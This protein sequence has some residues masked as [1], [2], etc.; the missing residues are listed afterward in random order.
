MVAVWIPRPGVAS[1]LAARPARRR[2]IAGMVVAG[3][4]AAIAAALGIPGRATYGAQVSADEPQYLLTALSLAEDGDLAVTDEL[5]AERYRAFHEAELPRQTAERPDG[6]HISPHD[7]LLP[8]M[9]APAMAIGGWIAAKLTLAAMAGVLA[10]LTVWTAVARFEVPLRLSVVTT[11]A[12]GMSAPLAVY[13]HQVYPELPAALIVLGAVAAITGPDR[14]PA[15]AGAVAAVI[16]LPWLGIKYAPVAATLAALLAWRL[17]TRQRARFAALTALAGVLAVAGGVYL[18]AHVAWYGGPTVYT[19][20]DFFA[21]NGG[22][23]AVVG[24]APDYLGRARRLLGLLVDRTFGVAAWQPAWLLMVPAAGAL[25]R[26]RPQRW[27]ALAWP[28]VVGWLVA[29]FVAV[30]MHGWWFPGRQVVAVLPLG[31][32]GVAWWIAQSGSRARL[33]AFAGLAALGVWS[34]G[35]LVA[36][37]ATGAVTWIVDFFRVPDPWFQRWRLFLPDYWHV[38]PGTW[39]LHVVWLIG[40]AAAFVSAWRAAARPVRRGGPGG[41]VPEAD[42]EPDP[43]PEPEPEAGGQSTLTLALPEPVVCSEPATEPLA[44]AEPSGDGQSVGPISRTPAPS[45]VPPHA[46]ST[47]AANTATASRRR[48]IGLL[49]L[50]DAPA[51]CLLVGVLMIKLG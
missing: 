39:V 28:F 3:L 25:L 40:L 22:Q 10:A 37:T 32:V 34:Y 14:R 36:G 27:T 23:L 30:T 15:V 20:G 43:E 12:F 33:P 17:W 24:T 7:P 18:V 49:R 1:R 19:A 5:A 16:A 13:G 11:A 46:V 47:K 4:L 51:S 26:R 6:A 31:V 2:L 44:D 45:S 41:Y 35:W 38:T 48:R 21:D 8:L 29:T 50:M 9:L 42:A